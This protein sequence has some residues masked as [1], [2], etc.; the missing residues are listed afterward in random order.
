M[1]PA[2]HDHLITF[3][4]TL[5]YLKVIIGHWPDSTLYIDVTG[6]NEAGIFIFCMNVPYPKT[7]FFCEYFNV[8]IGH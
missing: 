6:K 5:T 2:P 3:W 4:L 8:A 1:V 7:K